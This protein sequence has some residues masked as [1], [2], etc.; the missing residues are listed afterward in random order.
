[1][2]TILS[3]ISY[4]YLYDLLSALSVL[5][6]D[7]QR[8]QPSMVDKVEA[9]GRNRVASSLPFEHVSNKHFTIAILLLDHG[10]NR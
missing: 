6:S 8:T 7:S 10:N 2:H 9:K 4:R 1:M 3:L 5:A